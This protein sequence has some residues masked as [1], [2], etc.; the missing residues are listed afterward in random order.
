LIKNLSKQQKIKNMNKKIVATMFGLSLSLG[1]Y[2]Q[3]VIF[4]DSTANTGVQGVNG[5]TAFDGS[6]TSPTYSALVTANG[7][8]FT[9]DTAAQ[10]QNN[11]GPS[12]SQL[13]GQDFNFALYYGTTSGNA[14][15]LV[16]S[17]IGSGNI[18]GDNVN[19]GQIQLPSA[20]SQSL[21]GT[22]AGSPV[23]LDLQI[24]EGNFASYAAAVS[25]GG[26]AADSGAFSNPTGGGQTPPAGLSGLPDM[27]LTASVVPE[28]TSLAL[29]GLGG[30]GMLMALRRKQA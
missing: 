26:Y 25:G 10:W 24:W 6:S 14:T 1:V 22:T 21:T 29:A 11:G 3:G 15:T 23:F 16:T 27:I 12:G 17:L 20:A 4:I 28:P 30:F 2:A 9:T 13:I 18:T 7:M 5:G 19:W 8:I